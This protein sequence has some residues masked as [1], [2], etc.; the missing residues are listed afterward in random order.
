MLAFFV[1]SLWCICIVMESDGAKRLV[2]KNLK[3][4][5]S[6]SFIDSKS[7]EPL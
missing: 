3:H 5:L 6:Y 2:M 1:E 4:I 7:T